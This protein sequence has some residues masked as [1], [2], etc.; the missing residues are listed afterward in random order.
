MEKKPKIIIENKTLFMTLDLKGLGLYERGKITRR[1]INS[2][3]KILED[4]ADTI[5][6]RVLSDYG[7]ILL[8]T[9]DN[10]YKVALDKLKARF[11][12]ELE[13]V[14][15]Y[16]GRKLDNCY[17]IQRSKNKITVLLEENRYLICGIE[18]KE[19]KI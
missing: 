7:I 13:I 1:F 2:D 15:F 17:L 11:G 14:D 10:A 18:I 4:Y 3:T 12:V 6:K 9:E 8:D 19:R 16:K 5:I